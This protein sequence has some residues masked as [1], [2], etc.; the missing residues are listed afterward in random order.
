MGYYSYMFVNTTSGFSTDDGYVDAILRGYKAGLLKEMDYQNLTQCENLDDVRMHLSGTDY[1]N[2]MQNEPSP[3]SV[4]TVATKCLEKLC[5]EFEYIRMQATEPLR[6]F[7]DYITYG[8]MIDNIVLLLI[9]TLHGKD[10]SELLEKCHPLG[11]FETLPTLLAATNTTELYTLVLADTPLA[12]Y[13]QTSLSEADLNELNVEYIRNTL[14]KAYLEDFYK[15]CKNL[16]GITAEVMCKLLAFEADRRSINIT[17]NSFGSELSNFDRA[18]L[19]PTCG[20]LN[21]ELLKGLERAEDMDSVRDVLSANEVYSKLFSSVGFQSDRSL[22]DAFFEFELHMNKDSFN[23]LCHYGTFYSFVRMKEQE[24]RNIVWICE[25]IIQN[26][27]AK[28]NNYLPI[29]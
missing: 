19:Y 22:E 20:Y 8:Y 12:A 21:N 11:M 16:G 18:Q 29:N 4:S 26:Q 6:S 10:T 1:G 7:L 17:I 23:Q 9:G 24:I 15:F 25:C 27:R 28:I 5:T 3:L 14:Y 2:F 13:F